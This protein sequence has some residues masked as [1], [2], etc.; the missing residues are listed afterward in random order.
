MRH[1]AGKLVLGVMFAGIYCGAAA[2]SDLS[3][4]GQWIGQYPSDKMAGGKALWDQPGIQDV[5]RAAMGKHFAAFLQKD[6]RAPEAP[7]QS[8]GNGLFAAWTC[9]NGEDCGG[10][11]LTVFFDSSAGDAQVCWRSSEGAG[12]TVHD[13]WLANGNE[14]PLP[15]NGCGVGQRDPFASLKRYRVK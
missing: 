5:I 14:R 9:T 12:G 3:I 10:N 2:A 8:D 1:A 6:T 4:V 15:I 13:I 7:V 11:N